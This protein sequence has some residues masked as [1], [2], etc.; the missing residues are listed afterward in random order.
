MSMSLQKVVVESTI[1]KDR[2]VF[3]M[4]FPQTG[5]W[6][7]MVREEQKKREAQRISLLKAD[8][9]PNPDYR[10]PHNLLLQRSKKA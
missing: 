3:V 6:E 8:A 5:K 7:A 4:K 2:S 10:Q 1:A 9:N